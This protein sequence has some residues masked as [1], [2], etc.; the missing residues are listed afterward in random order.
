MSTKSDNEHR[1][2]SGVRDAEEVC[3][4]YSKVGTSEAEFAELGDLL[5][6]ETNPWEAEP[7]TSKED[8]TCHNAAPEFNPPYSHSYARTREKGRAILMPWQKRGSKKLISRGEKGLL[9]RQQL[10]RRGGEQ[11]GGS[12]SYHVGGREPRFGLGGGGC[13]TLGMARPTNGLYKS[14]KTKVPT[15]SV[16]R[17]LTWSRSGKNGV[18][19]KK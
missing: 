18:F 6:R 8:E 17:S 11:K 13:Q 1:A 9:L 14:L 2:P 5:G 3:S 19:E 4:L 10:W 7:S 12:I 15:R 16:S